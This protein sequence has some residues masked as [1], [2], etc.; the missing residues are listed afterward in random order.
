MGLRGPGAR[1]ARKLPARSSGRKPRR[2]SWQDPRLSRAERVIRFVEG[3]RITSGAHAGR[4]FT[5]RPWQRA[6][7]RAWYATDR[8][9]RR[10]VRTGL[11]SMGRKNGKTSTVAALALAHLLGPEVERRGQVVAA[12]ADRDQS[13]LVFDELVA[14]ITDNPEFDAQCNIQRHAKI[15]EHLPSGSKFR[16]LSSDAKKAHGMSPSV[17]IVD[18]LAQWG[19][20]PGRALYDALTTATGARAEPLTLI[21]STQSADEHSLMSEL[22]DYGKQV[23]AGIVTDPTFSAHIFEVPLDADPWDESLW[24]LANPALG[25]FRS[26]D[27]MRTF[28]ARAREMPTL[29]AAFRNFYLNQ[30]VAAD[31]RWIAPALWDACAGDVDLDALAGARCYG[32]LD[33]GSVRDLTAFALCWPESG[34]LAVWTWCPADA[35]RAREENDRVPYTV[36]AKAGHIEPTPGKATDK[37]RVALRLADLCAR[38]KPEAI[39]YDVWG[40][41]ELERILGEEGITLPLKPF[42]QGYKSMAPAMK[43]FE[44]RVL[45]RRITHDTNPVL[46]WAVSNVV[47]EVDAAGNVKPSKERSRERI[48]PVV[49]AIMAVGL[50]AQEP[51]PKTYDFSQPLLLAAR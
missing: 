15:I 31:E 46:T 39:A 14:F 12:A 19:S 2:P 30:R 5:L 49:A 6:I 22:V 45:N 29:E 40:I 18:E 17:V 4:R 37:R 16:A 38:F 26:A 25:D 35:L 8:Q 7:L 47:P 43:A 41:T 32:G 3:L 23:N 24:P 10:I 11:L 33:L 51:P 50:A 21:I 13:A 9:R 34:A 1:P 48:D 42:G 20:G 44:E 27:E 28:A 36:W